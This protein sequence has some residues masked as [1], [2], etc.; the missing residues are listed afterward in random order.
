MDP[1]TIAAIFFF[2]VVISEDNKKQDQIIEDQYQLIEDL[3]DDLY[4]VDTQLMKLTGA[5]ASTTARLKL[6]NDTLRRRVNA[7]E[8]AYGH[9]ENKVDLLHR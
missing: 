6:E 4:V 3:E 5:Y 7:L 8:S 1:I 2:T 9:L